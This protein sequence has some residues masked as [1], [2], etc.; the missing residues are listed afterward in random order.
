MHDLNWRILKKNETE[1][2]KVH[3]I[4]KIICFLLNII[5]DKDNVNESILQSEGVPRVSSSVA[6]KSISNFWL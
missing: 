1:P 6:D 5:I 3:L 4:V 2:D